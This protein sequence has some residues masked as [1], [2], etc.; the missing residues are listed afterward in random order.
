[1]AVLNASPETAVSAPPTL[2]VDLDGTLIA[3]DTLHEAVARALHR[4]P[5]L[6]LRSLV[7]F[8]ARRD[9]AQ[10]KKDVLTAGGLPSV[11]SLP[12]RDVVL[13]CIARAREAGADVILA[14]GAHKSIADAVAE[15]LGGFSAVLAT[16]DVNLTGTRKLDRIRQHLGE[17]P[18]DYIGDSAADLPIWA[19]AS[20][21]IVVAP[22][23]SLARR[24]ALQ[25]PASVTLAVSQTSRFGAVVKQLRL[26]QWSKNVL[27]FVP[28][29]TSHRLLDVSLFVRSLLTL[30]AFSFVASAIYVINDLID[31]EADRLHPLK[32]A[33]P[34]ASGAVSIRAA[35]G[36]TAL[37][38]VAGMSLASWLGY[39]LM[40]TLGVY[41]LLA[42]S[43]TFRLKRVLALDVVVLATL[44]CI[45][46]I[47]GG[48]AIGVD[49]SPWLL[50]TMIFE[51]F[52][53]AMVKRSIE[54]R[55]MVDRVPGR[56]YRASDRASV[57]I[58]GIGSTLLGVMVFALYVQDPGIARLYPQQR[59][60]WLAVPLLLY[61]SAR[62]WLLE[63]RGEIDDDP[64]IFVLKDRVSLL[65]F[66]L[67]GVVLVA[68]ARA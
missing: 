39:E 1:M 4:N 42:V 34:L 51:F 41:A 43:Y 6:L 62:L 36:L 49:L 14:T 45:R 18:F 31:I 24:L 57:R 46:V 58:L 35:S 38:A 59:L 63:D 64:L 12:F 28:L 44:Y 19:A 29:V 21:A 48:V 13:D 20:T 8:A 25:S 56:G 60:L 66:A 5:F 16:E 2:V 3:S 11:A 52:G 26:R 15:H 40:A 53:L 23:R 47:A 9:K 61:W 10:L 27:V 54:L 7:T 55:R 68:A 22:S 65:A 33:R 50:A 17:K 67:V 30:L 32:R 37:M